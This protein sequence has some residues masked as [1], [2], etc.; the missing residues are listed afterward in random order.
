MLRTAVALV[1]ASATALTVGA[2]SGAPASRPCRGAPAPRAYDHVL[3]VVL[4]NHSSSQVTGASPYLNSLA[5]ACGLA[6]DYSAITHPSLPNYLALTSGGTDGITSDCTDCSTPARSIFEQVG[7]RWRSYLE[8]IP[9]AG[10]TGASSGRYVKRHNPAA[11]YTRIAAAYRTR[12]VPLSRLRADLA[13]GAL[14]RFALVVPNLCDDEHDC[15]VD[16][17]DRWLAVWLPRILGSPTYTQGR[18][19]LFITYDEGTDA[20]NHVYTVVAS[21]SVRR[22]TV[23]EPVFDH[24]SLLATVERLLRLHCLANACHATMMGG[25][26]HL[27]AP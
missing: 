12:A 14:P 25:A 24:Y 4:E 18:T 6:A 19:A 3:L 23:S 17:G 16:A 1:L 27:L 15:A 7:G 11:Y 13:S 2:A 5:A 10:F 22:G 21:P 26:F 9:A 20:D 8:S